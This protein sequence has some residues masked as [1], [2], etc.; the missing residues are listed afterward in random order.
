MLSIL[1]GLISALVWGAGDFTGGL[2]SRKTGAFR[3]VLF[4]EIVG[5]LVLTPVAFAV[6]DVIPDNL[7]WMQSV[8]AGGLGTLGLVLLYHSLATGTMSIAAPVSALLAAALPVIVGVFTEGLPSGPTLMGFAFA[9]MAVWLVSQTDDGPRNILAHLSELRLP[10]L[11]GIGF[12][13][14]FILIHSASTVSTLWPMVAS[15]GGGLM[16]IFLFMLL[17]RESYR[18][19]VNVWPLIAL[20]GILDIGGNAF[21]ILAGQL[22]RLDVSAVLSSLYPGATV[23]LAGLILKERLSRTQ[24]FGIACALIAIVLF[25]L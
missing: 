25:A 3:V 23:I 7:A 9:L 20:N 19:P 24:W 17:R 8:L 15:R 4:A 21:Y 6:G 16:V 18:V 14:Y 12:G 5:M 1:Y 22:G 11:A 13:S 10:L 2:A